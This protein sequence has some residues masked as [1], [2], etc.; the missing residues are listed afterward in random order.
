MSKNEHNTNLKKTEWRLFKDCK[1]SCWV[2]RW[3]KVATKFKLQNSKWYHNFQRMGHYCNSNNKN[4]GSSFQHKPYKKQTNQNTFL[5]GTYG[6]NKILC[7]WNYLINIWSTATSNIDWNTLEL[8]FTRVDKLY[9][10]Y[11]CTY[12]RLRTQALKNITLALIQELLF[13]RSFIW[14]SKKHLLQSTN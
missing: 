5:I 6:V 9:V 11:L 12:G 10:N 8:S 1:M 4:N 13:L 14:D 7:Q 3:N 2:E